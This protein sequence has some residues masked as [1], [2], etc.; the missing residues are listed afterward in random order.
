[1]TKKIKL[2]RLITVLIAFAAVLAV[3]IAVPFSAEASGITYHENEE[4]AVAEL[5]GDMKQRKTRV[6]IGIAG[7][8]DEDGLQDVIGRLISEA[9]EHTGKPD[10]GD[11]IAFQYA[12]F[13]GM[14]R[15]TYSGTTPAYEIEYELAY[16][17][18]ADQ[19][20]EVDKK[21]REILEEL[22]L[23]EKT[24]LEKI[25]SIHDYLCDNIEY[26]AAEDDSDIRRTA[27]GA[28][29]EGKAVCQGYSVSLYR[30][31][32]EA[33]IDNRIIYG[34]GVS[35]FT[36]GGPH[37]WNIVKL[38]GEYYNMDVTWDDSTLSRDY[39]L[40][41]E[42]EGF[43]EEH[44]ADDEFGDD[45]FKEDH[46]LSDESIEMPAKGMPATVLNNIKNFFE[47]F[48]RITTG[49]GY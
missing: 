9:T 16:Y 20:A 43:E 31:L 36:E 38:D 26:E 15:T 22:E 7:S 1:M 25:T 48:R 32:L 8:I 46:P 19:E 27:Y 28:L 4:D 3:C 21:V 11:Y 29:V 45:T 10:E 18:D 30:L 23:D 42:G 37:T 24:D 12:S 41:P 39:F 47:A 5:R 6:T 34:T 33:G 40:V 35:D 14:A 17:D 44:I 49:K 2:N 13:K